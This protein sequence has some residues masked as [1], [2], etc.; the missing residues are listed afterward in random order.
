[1]INKIKIIKK[2]SRPD[3]TGSKFFLRRETV[4][5]QNHRRKYE[6]IRDDTEI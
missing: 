1:M 6:D 4:K 5:K 2:Y 3:K